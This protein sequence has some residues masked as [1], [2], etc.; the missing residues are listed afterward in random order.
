MGDSEL[1]ARREGKRRKV[2]ETPTQAGHSHA[3][4]DRVPRRLNPPLQYAHD[5]IAETEFDSTLQ[6]PTSHHTTTVSAAGSGAWPADATAMEIE[7]DAQCRHDALYAQ[8]LSNQL[9]PALSLSSHDDSRDGETIIVVDN[10]DASAPV[11]GDRVDAQTAAALNPAYRPSGRHQ[12]EMGIGVGDGSA[13]TT[14]NAGAAPPL[15][16]EQRVS[17]EVHACTRGEDQ[18]E[19]LERALS[20]A[21]TMWTQDYLPYQEDVEVVPPFG[22][23]GDTFFGTL[24]DRAVEMS[25]GL[26]PPWSTASPPENIRL[27]QI[28][29]SLRGKQVFLTTFVFDFFFFEKYFLRPGHLP[30]SIVVVMDRA[31]YNCHM[32]NPAFEYKLM[33]LHEM[34]KTNVSIQIAE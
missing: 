9:N 22:F 29:G 4:G 21:R 24:T 27:E 15:N 20:T 3:W 13:V 5:H 12:L 23:T 26:L 30:A 7:R 14:D 11:W 8:Q 17:A 25:A 1:S 28:L 18:L 32:K 6:P 33:Q 2:A 19:A 31:M 10:V 34:D 16:F